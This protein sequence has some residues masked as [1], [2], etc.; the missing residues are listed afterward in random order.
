MPLMN[1]TGSR[2]EFLLSLVVNSIF[3]LEEFVITISF[4]QLGYSQIAC[5]R[6]LG[7]GR[8]Y[9]IQVLREVSQRAHLWD[10]FTSKERLSSLSECLFFF[11]FSIWKMQ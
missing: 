4:L 2:M 5:A 11:D 9:C 6:T 7:I 8:D 3:T 1:A 10:S